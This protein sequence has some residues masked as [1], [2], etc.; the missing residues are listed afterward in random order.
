[1]VNELMDMHN[2]TILSD[3]YQTPR[4]LIGNAIR[5]GITKV[6]ISDHYNT[7]KCKS[8]LENRLEKYIDHLKM[9]KENYKN[10][11]DVLTGIEICTNR[12][13]CD[14]EKL[15][16]DRLNQLDYVLLEYVDLFSSSITLKEIDKYASKF[17]CRVG[18]AHTDLFET[19]KKYGLDFV[20]D[21]I[22]RNNLMWEINVNPGYK[23]FDYIINKLNSNEVREFFKKLEEKNIEI[24][25]GSDTHSILYYDIERLKQGNRLAKYI[26]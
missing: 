4:E 24:I 8:I 1:M 17:N 10:D 22:K 2:H 21:T 9:L 16:I 15:P 12:E 18:L 23:Y 19:S 6:G 5:N 7:I 25:V 11:I 3:G 14:L 13:W 20:I 26:V